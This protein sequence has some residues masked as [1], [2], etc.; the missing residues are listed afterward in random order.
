MC[1]RAVI[2]TEEEEFWFQWQLSVTMMTEWIISIVDH[3][4]K[5]I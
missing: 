1:I 3:G 2:H 5:L 4:Y